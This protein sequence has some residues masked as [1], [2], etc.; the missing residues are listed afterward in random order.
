MR[1]AREM[2]IQKQTT[3]I[4]AIWVNTQRGGITKFQ[5][6]K[7]VFKEVSN[8]ELCFEKKN[9]ETLG[10]HVLKEGKECPFLKKKTHKM[11]L[12]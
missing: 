7:K 2:K 11:C 10:R 5:C 1:T 3:K 8:F 6:D 12:P 9:K 4:S